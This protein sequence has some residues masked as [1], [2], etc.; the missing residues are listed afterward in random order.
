MNV[1]TYLR[2]FSSNKAS[3]KKEKE[4]LDLTEKSAAVEVLPPVDD[5]VKENKVPTSQPNN[6]TEG[7]SENFVVSSQLIAFLHSLWLFSKF[8]KKYQILLYGRLA[9]AGLLILCLMIDGNLRVTA[10][11]VA[12]ILIQEALKKVY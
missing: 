9:L 6:F 12:K 1:K 4:S 10:Y 11:I 3:S 8:M 2:R 7:S 5:K